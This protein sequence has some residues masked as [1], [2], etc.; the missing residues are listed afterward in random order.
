MRVLE[1]ELRQRS[2][3]LAN[4]VGL[5]F[6]VLFGLE[7]QKNGHA[8]S[9]EYVVAALQPQPPPGN[10]KKMHH[11]GEAMAIIPSS[12]EQ[13]CPRFFR[14]RHASQLLRNYYSVNIFE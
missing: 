13:R 10:L 12:F 11:L 5:G 7:V 6:A 2:A 9:R 3:D 8:G 14:V 1:V 4:L